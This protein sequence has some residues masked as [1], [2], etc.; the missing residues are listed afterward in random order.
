M[1]F[2]RGRDSDFSALHS[3]LAG[4]TM[5]IPWDVL[6]SALWGPEG[7]SDPRTAVLLLRQ[8]SIINVHLLRW[9]QTEDQRQAEQLIRYSDGLRTPGWRTRGGQTGVRDVGWHFSSHI[10]IC[11]MILEGLEQTNEYFLR[12]AGYWNHVLEQVALR[13]TNEG[14]APFRPT[15]ATLHDDFFCLFVC[16]SSPDKSGCK[17][18]AIDFSRAQQKINLF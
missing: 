1:R 8:A 11:T 10:H 14:H 4:V 9:E 12:H 13:W 18:H 5:L 7:L 3:T 15:S 6:P 16:F 17:H 2:S